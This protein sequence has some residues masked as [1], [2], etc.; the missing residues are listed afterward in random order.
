MMGTM[1]AEVVHVLNMYNFFLCYYMLNKTKRPPQKKKKE[2]LGP[3]FFVVVV[4]VLQFF[5]RIGFTRNRLALPLTT[6]A[7]T[8]LTSPF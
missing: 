1:F 2:T 8:F 6:R 4:H 5:A 3:L 7:F